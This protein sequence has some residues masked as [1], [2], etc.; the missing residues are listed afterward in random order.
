VIMATGPEHLPGTTAGAVPVALTLELSHGLH[1]ATAR[2]EFH[3][4]P[5]GR[6]ALLAVYGWLDAEAVSRLGRAL[7]DL[8]V[9]GVGHVLLDCSQ[10]EHVD[11]R[12]VPA[13]V[14]RLARFET[15]VAGLVVCGL[16]HYLRDLFRLAGCDAQLR[17][18]PSAADLL[19]VPTTFEPR[20]EC[21]S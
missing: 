6:V 10:L 20:R 13:L 21:A 9:Q 7:E 17:C 15:R 4:R 12:V 8:A 14:D 18:W 19:P 3:D 2:V 5:E 1:A 16:S 11:Y